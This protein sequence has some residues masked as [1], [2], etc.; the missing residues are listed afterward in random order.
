MV[1]SRNVED[2]ADHPE[3]AENVHADVDARH[4]PG[5]ALGLIALNPLGCPSTR[6]ALLFSST[7]AA[8]VMALTFGKVTKKFQLSF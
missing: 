5:Y 6:T 7:V 2:P 3:R 4:S 8:T 1:Q